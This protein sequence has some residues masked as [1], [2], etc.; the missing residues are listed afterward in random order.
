MNRSDFR[1]YDLIGDIHG[2]AE[3]LTRLLRSLGYSNSEGSFRHPEGRRVVFLGDFIDRGPAVRETLELVKEMIDAGT[4][5]AVMGNHEYNAICFHTP[6]GRG[7]FLRSHTVKDGKNV[8]QHRATLDAFAGR[9]DEWNDWID[10]FKNL[11]FALDLDGV[12]A[13][14]ASWNSDHLSVL[15]G[16]N[17]HASDFLRSS[18][19]PGT[20]AFDAIET[21][22]KG[23]EIPLPE[24]NFFEDKQGFKRSRIRVRWWE[25]PVDRTHRDVVFPDC[26][27]VADTPVELNTPW[28]GYPETAPPVFVGHYWLPGDQ[29]PAPLAPNVACLDYSVAKPGGKLVGYCWD[30][31]S[32]LRTERFISVSHSQSDFNNFETESDRSLAN[33]AVSW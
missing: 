18:A 4:A 5:L 21:L 3:P 6:D 32:R 28:D 26:A 23:I 1:N 10:W 16:T 27:T 30:G 13:V 2:Y 29:I 8:E 14:H 31:E 19:I 20:P 11:P 24:D 15:E 9:E 25:S 12:R 33:S 17:L 22:L 7:D